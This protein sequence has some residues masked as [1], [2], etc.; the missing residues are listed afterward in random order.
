MNVFFLFPGRVWIVFYLSQ[1]SEQ[2]KNPTGQKH[3]ICFGTFRR[4][5]QFWF[6]MS[7]LFLTVF[8]ER[9]LWCPSQLRTSSGGGFGLKR[10]WRA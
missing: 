4:D 3:F 5:T 1:G 6:R 10:F 9:T 7:I 8:Q 2:T